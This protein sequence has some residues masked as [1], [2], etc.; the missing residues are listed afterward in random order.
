MADIQANIGIGVDTTQAL[1][2]IRQL[3]REISVFHTLMAKGGADAAA[4]SLQMQQ[5]LINTINETGKFSASMTRVSSSTESFTNALEK[6]KLSMGQ[7]F[8]YA[9]GASKSFGKM[10]TKEFNT[11]NRVATERVKDLQTQYIS[12][13]RDAN[14]A[15]QAIKVRPLAL[16]MNNLGTKVMFAAQK[17]QIFN[18]LLKQGTTNLLN[19]GK[20]TQWAGRQLMV[21]FT[22]PLTIFG[23]TAAREFQ[24]LEE[25]AVKFRRVYGDMFTTDADTEKALKNVRELADEFTK[26]GIA[27][28]KTVGLAAKVAQMGNV[29]ED[30][31]AQV[32]QATRL[33][34]LGGLEQEEA[35][36]TTISLTNAFGIAAEDLAGKIAFLNAAENQT[37]LAIE[38]FNEAIPKA[39]SVV[40]QLGGDV[41]DLAFMLT[42]MREGGINASQAANAIKSSLGR[43]INPTAA[44]TEKLR[45]FGIDIM[46]IVEGNVGNLNGTIMQLGYA[47]DELDPL[48]RA[49]AIETLF[50]KFQFARM[51]TMFSNIVKEGSQANRVL[52]LTTNS[53][54]ELA[55]IAERELKR[56]EESPAFKLQKQMEQLRASLAPIGEEFIK[57]V[58]PIIEFGTKLLKSFNNLGDGGK[59]F[60]VILTAVAG[61]VAPALLMGFGLIANGVANLIKFFLFLGNAFGRLS[62]QST[63]LGG[64]TEYMTQ[65][66][67]EAAAVAASLGQSHSNLTQ[68]FTSEASAVA[69]LVTQYRAAITAQRQLSI[70]QTAAGVA[71]RSGIRPQGFATGG[72]VRGP[73]TGTSDSIFAMLSNGE[74]VL[75]AAVVKKYPEAVNQLI[76]GKVP[77]YSEAGIVS[78]EQMHVAGEIPQ[79]EQVIESVSRTFLPGFKNLEQKFKDF[80]IILGDL[81]ATKSRDLNQA[82]KGSGTYAG[83]DFSDPDTFKKEWDINAGEGFVGTAERATAAGQLD[84]TPETDQ[85]V[86]DL[87]TQIRDGVV[88]ELPNVSEAE[89][90][91]DGWLDR[92]IISVTNKVIDK[93]SSEGTPA[94]QQV[95]SAMKQRKATPVTARS[96]NI[97]EKVIDPST[98]SPHKT[99]G[100]ALAQL[101][102]EGSAER[103]PGERELFLTGSDIAVGRPEYG[104]GAQRQ[105]NKA[106]ADQI[107]KEG[108]INQFPMRSTSVSKGVTAKFVPGGNYESGPRNLP[109]DTGDMIYPA[110]DVFA[111]SDTA[112]LISEARQTF[113]ELGS[114][115][116]EGAVS[117]WKTTAQQNSPSKKF[118]GL[119]SVAAES[120]AD[121]FEQGM[122]GTTGKPPLP[123]N[124]A[125]PQPPVMPEA[126]QPGRFGRMFSGVKD[127]I[128]ESKVAQ[129]AADYLSGR[130]LDDKITVTPGMSDAER[131][132]HRTAKAINQD[133]YDKG[134]ITEDMQATPLGQTQG[135]TPVRVV[136]GQLD[137]GDNSIDQLADA[138]PAANDAAEQDKLI[139]A[140]KDNRVA[141]EDAAEATGDLAKTQ[142]QKNKDDKAARKEEKRQNR[143]AR[144]GKAL[145]GLGTLTMAA[146]MA[147]QVEGVVGETAQKIVGPLAALSGIAPILMA[148]PLPLAALVAVV[149][150]GV[151]AFMSYNKMVNDARK[152]GYELAEAF[153]TGEKAMMRFAEFAGTVGSQERLSARTDEFGRTLQRPAGKTTFG[154]SF[155]Q[156]EENQDYIENLRSSL[157]N[158]GVDA[159]AAKLTQQLSLAVADKTLT[160][161][162]ARSISAALGDELGSYPLAIDV[163]AKLL[164]LLGPNGEDALEDPLQLSAIIAEISDDAFAGLADSI[165]NIQVDFS[166]D[167]EEVLERFIQDTMQARR[168][169][170]VDWMDNL[171]APFGD[172]IVLT[173]ENYLK[174]LGEQNNQKDLVDL[175]LGG[176]QTGESGVKALTNQQKTGIERLTGL[177]FEEIVK[178]FDDLNSEASFQL[179]EAALRFKIEN[180]PGFMD[181]IDLSLT[182]MKLNAENVGENAALMQ[183][184]MNIYQTGLATQLELANKAIDEAKESGEI[185]KIRE[186]YEQRNE[187]LLGIEEQ[188][189]DN[190]AAIYGG[191]KDVEIP[192]AGTETRTVETYQSGAIDLIPDEKR[193][194]QFKD[195]DARIAEGLEGSA[196]DMANIVLGAF[197]S[198][199]EG[200]Q[201]GVN[202]VLRGMI[203]DGDI[204]SEELYGLLAGVDEGDELAVKKALVEVS[205]SV[206]EDYAGALARMS[207]VIKD[208]VI[209]AQFLLDVGD[210]DLEPGEMAEY[211]EGLD[212][213]IQFSPLFGADADAAI[214]DFA[215]DPIRLQ[216]FVEIQSQA[217]A[218]GGDYSEENLQRVFGETEGSAIYQE[219]DLN[220]EAFDKFDEDSKQ[221]FVT[222]VKVVFDQ[223]SDPA[224]MALLKA[225]YGE[226]SVTRTVTPYGPVERPVEG[227]RGEHVA[228]LIPEMQDIGKENGDPPPPG[229]KDTGAEP[230]VDSLIKKLRDLRRATVDMKKGWEGMQEV[231]ADLFAGGTKSINVFDGLSNQIRKFDV[232]ENLIE[233]IVGMDPDE[234]EKRK[235]ELFTFDK[236]GNIT[237]IT[238][239]LKNMNAALGAIALGEYVNAQQAF[240]ENTRNQITA[241]STLTANGLS[242]SEAYQVVQDEAVAAKIAMG[243]TTEEIRELVRITQIAN[244]LREDLEEQNERSQISEAVRKT[245]EEFENRVA[246]LDRLSKSAGQYTDA[247]IT[248]LLD[249]TNLQKL[250]LDPS[251]DQGALNQALRNAERNAEIEL[252]VKLATTEGTKGVFEEGFAQAMDAFSRQEQEIELNF[253]AANADDTALVEDAQNRIADIQYQLDDYNAELER[254]SWQEESINDKYDQ[255]FEALESIAEVNE[256]ISREQEAQLDIA[257]ALSR[258]DI[259][260]AARAQQEL[261]SKQAQDAAKQQRD[262]LEQARDAEV[263]ALTSG[264]MTREQLEDRIQGLERQIFAIEESDLEPAQ[265]RLRLQEIIKQDQIESLVVLE[266]TRDEWDRI[267]NNIDIAEASGYKFKETMQQAL[268]VVEKLMEAYPEIKPAPPPPPAPAPKAPSGGGGPELGQPGKGAWLDPTTGTSI[269]VAAQAKGYSSWQAY[270]NAERSKLDAGAR[271]MAYGGMVKKYARGGMII[272]KR[273][274]MGGMSMGSDII[275]A[276]LT[277]GEFVVRRPAVSA[278]GA[279]NLEKINRGTYS[280][281][282]V[283]NYN[284]AV[285][286]KSDSD[287]N[288]IARAVMTQ[289]KGIENQRIRSNR[290]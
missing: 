241:I 255:R 236:A 271:P 285:N 135:V 159:T 218:L 1:A 217:A 52:Q 156:S 145:A 25:Q 12:M 70:G 254:I 104:T 244:G 87:D 5:G 36:D 146:G 45:G 109:T 84:K 266:K 229:P 114:G 225:Q 123:G 80:F 196:R 187:I 263:A 252:K 23:A 30:L 130:D 209:R 243:A 75:S 39:G 280:D 42:A 219:I 57:A 162:Q 37:I 141:Q 142:E 264:G 149:G 126:A 199:T 90:A 190:L 286:V 188:A 192:A 170:G 163:N 15:L 153:G 38:D 167:S 198:E 161:T 257:D 289:I 106:I 235:N 8:R 74:A 13:G 193:G 226:E 238:A 267:K 27:V 117:G 265:E 154:E 111:G 273:M 144:A 179:Q 110:T 258:G 281:G 150:A 120:L 71:A 116:V 82:A 178:A 186:A 43:M 164:S 262:M 113:E 287:P 157:L 201:F 185:D 181:Q 279:D 152:K 283:Y 50:G 31:T 96:V 195:Q 184:W 191:Y 253:R 183:S 10:F 202:S 133:L 173:L 278:F 245:N 88:A 151:W 216:A 143:Q 14:G 4:K 35:L 128:N 18:Q 239:K 139:K 210:K 228:G 277:P 98:G 172:N 53:T 132:A 105:A 3:Q 230:Q 67:L 256:R 16:D 214:A 138:S 40:Q 21:G 115:A 124:L 177:T 155:V 19:F 197:L 222:G 168:T 63:L 65:Q 223:G 46:G 56:V 95:A 125:A 58:G 206:G 131:E 99:A 51:S 121:G 242:L 83:K 91:V 269:A 290:L 249:D 129:K 7:Y 17:Q 136:D 112:T 68:I 276:I 97:K 247:Q 48:N 127:K 29:G 32:T 61:V 28:E 81:V 26:Y 220:R 259:A 282:T 100:A 182:A 200:A 158:V 72:L 93:F 108:G 73:G 250:M 2:A 204:K 101:E 232:G 11:I 119:G 55:I 234:Y 288:R 166:A 137:I 20:N 248:A 89:K 78:M 86:R 85:A 47:L 102:A 92:L 44:A 227:V 60:I 160:L 284:L 148:L 9:G 251:I 6:N 94:E 171:P 213:A 176:I 212:T 69:G 54:E 275:P 233:M 174:E 122:S 274:A 169:G 147:T 189:V 62:G 270:Y 240:I 22:I 205:F 79:T 41:E 215:K 134:L 246:V 221:L 165:Q 224:L 208:P 24:K 268:D 231:L 260:G 34:V 66:Q 103:R 261:R 272:P 207:S 107:A 237:G 194:A 77:G 33:A 64:Q 211:I 203:E 76:S 59:Q 118:F 49:R 180:D 175:V 140:T